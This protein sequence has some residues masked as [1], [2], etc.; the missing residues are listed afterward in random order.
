MDEPQI[1]DIK[2]EPIH[3]K[4]NG[5]LA[6]EV[7]YECTFC[8]KTMFPLV[9]D[10][11]VMYANLSGSRYHCPFCIRHG[12]NTRNSKHVLILSF[13]AIIGYYYHYHYDTPTFEP[14]LYYSEIKE[15][16]D[17]HVETGLTNP[18]FYYDP[19]TY[20]WFVDF[21]KVG[22]GRKKISVNDTLKTIS[23]ILL[24]FNLNKHLVSPKIHVLYNKYAE[25]MR[26]W[27]ENRTRPEGKRML[28]PTLLGCGAVPNPY[29][30]TI[31]E[32]KDFTS[33]DLLMQR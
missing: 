10:L 26:K 8:Q 16:V 27:Y 23:N 24:C 9:E 20:L 32:T 21:G 3:E 5:A 15:I 6:H 31:D 33:R 17:F 22:H 2:I 4:L 25:A 29:G 19:E 12:F 30:F 18:V 14:K 7:Y 28:I 1:A 11:K 13:R